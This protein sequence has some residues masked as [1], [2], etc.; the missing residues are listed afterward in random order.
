MKPLCRG[1]MR[2]RLQRIR[3]EIL[4]HLDRSGWAW[5]RPLSLLLDQV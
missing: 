3:R 2:K 4:L 5:D 1:L